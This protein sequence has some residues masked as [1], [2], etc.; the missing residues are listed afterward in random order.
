MGHLVISCGSRHD[1]LRSTTF[2][3]PP[4]DI[5]HRHAGPGRV[6]LGPWPPR[7]IVASLSDKLSDNPPGLGRTV[8]GGYQ[9]I[10]T[11]R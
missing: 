8:N 1:E 9:W 2:Y 10:V 4:H 7:V 6:V 5:R 3:E 11:S